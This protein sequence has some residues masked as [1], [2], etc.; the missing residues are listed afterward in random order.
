MACVPATVDGYPYIPWAKEIFGTCVYTPLDQASLWIGL[1]SI[2]FWVFAQLPQI[3]KNFRLM[4]SSSLSPVFLVLWCCGDSTNLIGALLTNQLPTQIYLAIFFVFVDCILVGQWFFFFFR[5]RRLQQHAVK[6]VSHH[7]DQV[8]GSHDGSD[9]DN[10]DFS[11]RPQSTSSPAVAVSLVVLFGF[12]FVFRPHFFDNSRIVSF[13]GRS[14]LSSRDAPTSSPPPSGPSAADIAGLVAAWIS[15]TLYLASRA[16]QIVRN[17]RRKSTEG[18]ALTMF[19]CAVCGNITYSLSVLLRNPAWGEVWPATF[20]FLVGS[21]GT[22]MFDG[23]IFAQFM[24]YRK[25]REE[26]RNP[27]LS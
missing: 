10:D 7:D 16:P 25:R 6:E 22:L 24:L 19:A 4:D 23:M 1:A 18:L 20:P 12:S 8:W 3:I 21:L 17:F 11:A 13:A 5:S 2:G 9:D 27:L 15:A 26:E 14:L